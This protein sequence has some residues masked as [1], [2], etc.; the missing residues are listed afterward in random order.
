MICSLLSGKIQAAG[1]WNQ[2]IW[3]G[4]FIILIKPRYA[5]ICYF[6]SLDHA[7]LQ[8]ISSIFRRSFGTRTQ[9]HN[10]ERVTEEVTGFSFTLPFH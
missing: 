10:K 9:K 6:R 3:F 2:Q 4:V 5:F 8:L 7:D 1:H